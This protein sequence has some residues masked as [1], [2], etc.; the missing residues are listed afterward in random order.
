MTERPEPVALYDRA[1]LRAWRARNKDAAQAEACVHA[2]TDDITL[3]F[4]AAR[5]VAVIGGVSP[6]P[7]ATLWQESLQTRGRIVMAGGME[8]IGSRLDA[9]EV[10]VDAVLDGG[11][12]TACAPQTLAM[13]AQAR[14]PIVALG[15][16]ACVDPDRGTVAERAYRARVTYL[17]GATAIGIWTGA[18]REHCGQFQQVAP[19]SCEGPVRALIPG[20]GFLRDCLVHRPWHAHKGMAGTVLVIGGDEGMPGAVRLAAAGAYRAGAGLVAAVVHACNAPG[21]SAAYPE[22]IALEASQA[23]RMWARADV[24][25]IGPGLGRGPF[26]AAQWAAWTE[27]RIPT[28]VDGDGLYWLAQEGGVAADV[29]TP[30]EGEAAR[31]LGCAVADVSADRPGAARAIARRYAAVCVLKGGGTIIDD[32]AATWVCP[33][34]NPGM[35]TA[36]MGDV[37]AGI[38]GSLR[39]QGSDARSAAIAGVF[40]HAHA[41]DAAAARIG[42]RGLVARDVVREIP[43]CLSHYL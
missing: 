34:G 1:G 40:L 15:I 43:G 20:A 3:R 13:L 2:V 17:D 7:S 9:A 27:R 21:L 30:H 10:I 38:I 18:G 26:A 29:V 31:L 41:G 6:W 23:G 42:P 4:P 35:A 39:A 24:V 33:F 22:L 5:T 28:V 36:G 32:G 25:V 11:V 37:L 12:A 19:A 14:A 16:P 8:E